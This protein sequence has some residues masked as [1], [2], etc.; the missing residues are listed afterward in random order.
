MK[1]GQKLCRLL[2]VRS[3]T[4]Y[5]RV[6]VSSDRQGN[7]DNSA[8]REREGGTAVCSV[9]DGADP[10]KG[11]CSTEL[12]VGTSELAQVSEPLIGRE[13]DEADAQ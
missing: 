12:I 6:V 10:S 1:P 7:D 11:R 9:A 5:T 13:L 3:N 4:P 2:H 8:G